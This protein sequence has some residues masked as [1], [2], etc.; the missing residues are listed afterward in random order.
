MPDRGFSFRGCTATVGLAREEAG[1]PFQT[2]VPLPGMFRGRVMAQ[3]F[4]ADI[5]VADA[6]IVE[7][8]ALAMLV[9]AHEFQLRTYLRV[10][11]LQVGLLLNFHARRLVDGLRRFI[12]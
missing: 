10:S 11:G 9:P 1:L 5:V 8:K 7:V 2:Q 12:V 6:A 4:R 3:A